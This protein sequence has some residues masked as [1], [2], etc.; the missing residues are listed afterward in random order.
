VAS[1]I[2]A[3]I[4]AGTFLGI[5]RFWIRTMFSPLPDQTQLAVLL[6]TGSDFYAIAWALATVYAVTALALFILARL[7]ISRTWI[8]D[9]AAIVAFMVFFVESSVDAWPLSWVVMALSLLRTLLWIFLWRRLGFLALLVIWQLST[10]YAGVVNISTG[11]LATESMLV[12]A[13]PIL[14]ALWALWVILTD[15]RSTGITTETA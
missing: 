6:E 9:T 5:T 12:N 8:A 15:K 14:L 2:L 7:M 3:G 4:A 13:V 1:H 11:W 10:V